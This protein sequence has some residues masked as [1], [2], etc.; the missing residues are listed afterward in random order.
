MDLLARRAG[1]HGWT[2]LF[3]DRHPYAGGREHY[4]AY[5]ENAEG[6]EVELVA[7]QNAQ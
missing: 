1:S 4:A 2:L 3:R 5:L 6:F 7:D